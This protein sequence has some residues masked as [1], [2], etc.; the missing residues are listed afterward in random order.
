[1]HLQLA[2]PRATFGMLL[3]YPSASQVES[4]TLSRM[5]IRSQVAARTFCLPGQALLFSF[6][7]MM[8]HSLGISG[9]HLGEVFVRGSSL[10]HDQ[11]V[12]KTSRLRTTL[13]PK[14]SYILNKQKGSKDSKASICQAIIGRKV[15]VCICGVYGVL[16]Q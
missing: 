3:L 2:E 13:D 5:S 12:L 16:L 11:G 7:L 4:Q 6:C 8:P 1:M 14:A 15:F 9:P 10:I